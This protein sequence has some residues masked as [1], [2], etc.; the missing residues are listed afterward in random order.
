MSEFAPTFYL[1]I[2]GFSPSQLGI[3]TTTPTASQLTM[4][5]PS[6]TFAEPGV[7]AVSNM[8]AYPTQM[9]LEVPG[10]SLDVAQRVTFEYGLRFTGTGMFPAA[11]AMPETRQVNININVGGHN[12]VAP[13]TLFRQ[14]NPYML[15]GPTHWL[16]KDLRV[17]AL[18][19]GES[20]SG[21]TF[22]TGTPDP[23]GYLSTFVT[24]CDA[25][26]PSLMHP[27]D[28]ITPDQHGSRLYWTENHEGARSSTSPSRGCV[29][30]ASPPRRR[31][32]AYSSARSPPPS[33]RWPTAARAIR[34]TPP[35]HFRR[36][37][38]ARPR[39]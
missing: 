9:L 14:P 23:L 16:S 36:S 13:I 38:R 1:I 29:I 10:A 27:F 8:A 39:C 20:Q 15:D 31:T 32:C 7:G 6:A 33:P 2:H 22:P 26:A 28:Q 37:G 4:F 11:G 5:A 24:A 3:T 30:A 25:A 12:C 18:R 19:A 34:A 17:F 21:V 35:R